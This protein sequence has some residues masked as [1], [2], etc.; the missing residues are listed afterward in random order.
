MKKFVILPDLTCDLSP[1][2]R[3]RFGLQEYISGYLH[4]NDKSMRSTLD[5]ESISREE[6]YKTLSSKHNQVSTP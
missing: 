5:W 4:I 1:E 3:E 6:F 2:L